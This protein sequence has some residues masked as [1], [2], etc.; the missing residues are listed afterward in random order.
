MRA[1]KVCKLPVNLAKKK[2]TII[3]QVGKVLGSRRACLIT[4]TSITE[5]NANENRKIKI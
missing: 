3:R 1:V 5:G 4:L 2:K